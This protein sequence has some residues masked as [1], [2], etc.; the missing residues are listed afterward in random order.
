MDLEKTFK[1]LCTPAQL[2]FALSAI[3]VLSLFLATYSI[4]DAI[5]GLAV[6]SIW[7]AI[8]NM[9]CK[10]GYTA[11]SWVILALPVVMALGG[12]VALA[13]KATN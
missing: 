6:A 1:S 11:I 10:N 3:S 8:L 12:G 2:Y 4:F 5:V 7:A 9:I 13:S